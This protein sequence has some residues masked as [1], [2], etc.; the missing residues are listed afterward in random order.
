MVA[1]EKLKPP[2]SEA[3]LEEQIIAF[4]LFFSLGDGF[5]WNT[6]QV[7]PELDRACYL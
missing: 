3:F 1:D 5:E 4:V 2:L 6:H 7:W